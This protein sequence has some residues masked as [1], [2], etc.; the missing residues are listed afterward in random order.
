MGYTRVNFLLVKIVQHFLYT[1]L[2]FVSKFAG[3]MAFL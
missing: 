1:S 2:S 3:I